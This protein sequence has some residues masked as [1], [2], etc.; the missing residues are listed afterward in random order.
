MLIQVNHAEYNSSQPEHGRRDRRYQYIEQLADQLELKK[1]FCLPAG[2]KMHCE[3]FE[4]L[5]QRIWQ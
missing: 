4:A 1:N 3:I 5:M 2:F